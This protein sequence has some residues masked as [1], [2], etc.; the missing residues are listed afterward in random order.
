MTISSGSGPKSTASCRYGER[1]QRAIA[2]VQPGWLTDFMEREGISGGRPR[3]EEVAYDS[4]TFL[5]RL[6][7]VDKHRRVHLVTSWPDLVYWAGDQVNGQQW[8]WG[9][10]PF[11]DGSILGRLQEEDPERH[12]VAPPA[13]QHEMDL[14]VIDPPEA[15]HNDVV[16][17][18]RH[19][20]GELVNRVIPNVMNSSLDPERNP[21]P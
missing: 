7:N 5:N 1:D 3:E 6:S 19:I 2:A 14:R 8:R 16:S 15:G 12:G 18:L 10:P 21:Y 20:L 13:L 17:L 4:L 11:E 9:R